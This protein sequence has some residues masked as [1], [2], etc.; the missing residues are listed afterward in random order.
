MNNDNAR[1]AVHF[2]NAIKVLIKLIKTISFYPPGHPAL[3][4]TLDEALAAFNP[5][6]V[7]GS[8]LVCQ[9]RRDH[10]LLEGTANK[11]AT[12][13][14]Q[15]L[16]AFFFSRRVQ[17]LLLHAD[18]SGHDLQGFARVLAMDAAELK[19]QG[20]MTAALRSLRV[21]GVTV[22]EMEAPQLGGA[23]VEANRPGKEDKAPIEKAPEV[24]QSSTMM[25]EEEPLTEPSPVEEVEAA[26]GATSAAQQELLSLLVEVEREKND[27][28][29]RFLVGNLLPRLRD[30]LTAENTP[31]IVRALTVLAIGATDRRASPARSASCREAL[32]ELHSQVLF[33]LLIDELSSRSNSVEQ[34]KTIGRLLTFFGEESA[35]RLM[36][37]LVTEEQAAA[38]KFLTE[39]VIQQG[40]V[41]VPVLT[42]Y[43]VD[44]RW[45]VVRNAVALLGEIRDQNS[46]QHLAPLLDHDDLRVRREAVR[47][48]TRIGGDQA[49]G[50]LLQMATSTDVDLCRQALLSL[51]AL[52]HGAAI[53]ALLEIIRRPDPF[54]RKRELTREAVWALGEI[55]DPVAVPELIKL[56]QKRQFWNSQM[57]AEIRAAAAL[58]LGEIGA[59]TATE[60]LTAAVQ[61]RQ[62]EVSRAAVQ[63]L[64]RIKGGR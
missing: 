63:A 37:R 22:E 24:E 62:E 15:K 29:F 59:V 1:Q 39:A 49:V 33:D 13:A 21:A 44:S 16:A 23:V 14:A 57:L 60:A 26:G 48:L 8:A 64:R 7:S 50:I 17:R 46:A 3:Q 32:Q 53:P 35:Q 4:G 2:D 47:A 9:V 43:L 19:R 61:D 27:E 38:R 58:A 12:P 51:G 55:G 40:K 31:L 25:P 54:L 41:A 11:A 30:G 10:L 56:M 36:A 45:F 5:L 18:L 52:R 42:P 34:R 20:G 6:L 28:R